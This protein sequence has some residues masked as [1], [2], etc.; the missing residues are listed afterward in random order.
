MLQARF[1]NRIRDGDHR[2]VWKLGEGAGHVAVVSVMT[3]LA[4]PKL[5]GG[6]VR[7]S[8]GGQER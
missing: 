5:S 6:R 1:L 8:L 3:N 4:H 7:K 2:N